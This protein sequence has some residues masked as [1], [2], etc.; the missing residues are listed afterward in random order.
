MHWDAPQ[1]AYPHQLNA[2]A[3]LLDEAVGR[4]WGDR[5][6]MIAADGS[7]SLTYGELLDWSDRIAA[8]LVEDL[9]LQPG[10][11][12]LLRCFNH[13]WAVA[14]WFAVVRAGGVV[15]T[16]MPLLRRG[17]IQKTVD[18]AEI[19]LALCDSRLMGE[20][21]SLTGDVTVVPWGNGGVDD[22]LVRAQ[23]KTSGLEPVN[24]A[25]DDVALLAFTSGT[26]GEPKCTMHFHRDVLAIA[27][28]FNP[29]LKPVSSDVF[30]GSPPL[31]FTFGLGGLVIFPMRV[32]ASTVLTERPGDEFLQAIEDHRPTTCFTAP[33]A[34]R[35]M[36]GAK[37][38]FDL[39]SLRSGVSAGET[40]PK[41][42]WDQF[43]EEMGIELIDGIGATELLHIFISASGD[44]IR[45]GATGRPLLGVE[46][47]VVDEE[48][49][50]VV[51][52][53][54]G[55]L[56]VQAP[57]GCRYL[58]DDRQTEYVKEGWNLTGD[59]Y[60]CDEDGYFWYQARADDMIISSGYNI[61]GP[62]VEASLLKH[63]SVAECAVIGVPDEMRTELVKAF[64]VL[65]QEVTS[66]ND[67]A[68][69][70]QGFVRAD[71]APFK[72]PRQVEFV[73][74]LPKTQTG[75]VQRYR[76]RQSEESKL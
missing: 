50:P 26:T 12:V 29:V 66:S 51:D 38:R 43:E 9:D 28:M 59:A 73:S 30:C 17:E 3:G 58:S 44:D 60:I 21:E 4:S 45:P 10:N 57:T 48:M 18:K 40:L 23:S 16:T 33:T 5:P 8:V 56:A 53:E 70:L 75:K 39:T 19:S 63:P 54:V 52:G 37:S 71:I 72:Y 25:A 35:A 6:C 31:A 11:R 14:C 76:L 64:V 15:V 46:A 68:E 62:E 2:G 32:G 49:S 36:M 55:L 7:V 47:K 1:F 67:L 61:A 13:P 27:E 24:T 42:T 22:L 74:A 41:P 34:Y 20:M 65:R 69:E